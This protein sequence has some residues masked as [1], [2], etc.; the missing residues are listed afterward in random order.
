ML[1]KILR[2]IPH[3]K[4]SEKHIVDA[5]ILLDTGVINFEVFVPDWLKYFP[6]YPKPSKFGI[7][8][9]LINGLTGKVV[10]L[11]LRLI[12]LG[13]F[14]KIPERKKFIHQNNGSADSTTVQGQ[15]IEKEE[16]NPADYP[17]IQLC[18]DPNIYEKLII[19]CDLKVKVSI[20]KGLFNKGDFVVGHGIL[21][22]HLK[23]VGGDKV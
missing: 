19:D 6:Y 8:Q 12:D 11:E 9:K 18:P 13:P 16:Y 1:Y 17:N 5:Y 10:E 22:A 4:E 3:S 23:K 7:G 20:E 21:Q 15:V 14:E 2:V